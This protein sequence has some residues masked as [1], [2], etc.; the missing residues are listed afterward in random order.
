[1]TTR[2]SIVLWCLL[3]GSIDAMTA[4][5]LLASPTTTLRLMG[6]EHAATDP[7]YLRWIG[8]F[9]GGVALAYLYPL[10]TRRTRRAERIRLTLELTALMRSGVGIFTLLAIS[11]GA[12]SRGWWSVPATDLSFALVQLGLLLRWPETPA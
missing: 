5:L 8:V 6:I 9:V 2:R 11:N 7:V 10:V 3:V 4:L 1:M 12:L